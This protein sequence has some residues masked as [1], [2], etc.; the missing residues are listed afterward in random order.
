[1]KDTINFRNNAQQ[2]L[3]DKEIRGQISDGHWEN[4]DT[5]T[6]LWYCLAKVNSKNVGSSWKP[7]P[8]LDFADEDLI[9]FLGDRM[10]DYVLDSGVRKRYTLDNLRADLLDMT[11]IVFELDSESN[12]A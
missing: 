4:D 7:S 1:M 12:D 5:D 9:E 2:V 11:L 8:K 6:R 10:I 3:Y